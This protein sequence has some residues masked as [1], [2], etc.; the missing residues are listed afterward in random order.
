MI[1]RT[2]EGVK[3]DNYINNMPLFTMKFIHYM[4]SILLF[5]CFWV[6]FRYGTFTLSGYGF[7]YNYYVTV[8]YA[9]ILLLFNRTYNAYLLGFTRV[10]MLVF[11][12]FLS[13]FFSVAIVWGGAT[14]AWRQFHA[15]WMLLILLG[16]QLIIDI[17]WSLSSTSIYFKM[18]EVK[19]TVFVYRKDLDKLR[20]GSIKG[21]SIEKLYKIEKEIQ[22]DGSFAELREQLIGYD[23]IFVAGVNSH[24]RNGILKF[25]KEEGIPG[26]FLPHVGDVIMQDATHI[27]SFDT[28]VLYVNRKS[29][30][31]EYAIIKRAFDIVASLLGIIVLSPIMLITALC[32][33]IY[34]GGPALYKQVRLTKNGREFNVL[35]FRSM[36]VDAE[37]DGVARLS[38][39][40]L[41]SRVTPIGKVIRKCRAD[42]IPQLFNILAGS[43]S[44]VGPRPERPEIAMQYYEIMPDFQ[45]RLQVRAGL[46]GYAQVYGRYNTDPYQKLEFDLL[47]IRNMNVL[48]DIRLMFATI[49]ILFMKEST[50]GIEEGQETAMKLGTREKQTDCM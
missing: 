10:R 4:L 33:K 18:N 35:K 24:C 48:T 13:Q 45:L 34:D 38:T 43:M 42:E 36:S 46:T 3:R 8:I 49:S 6:L 14:I 21:K 30:N 47:Y 16:I 31:V 23:A 20:F 26:Y 44:I 40:T 28:P 19:R 25:C 7:R 2:S 29:L 27:Q 9:V 41:D 22:Y 37:K 12:Q 11:C 17:A 1:K 39:G 5:F 50:E 32:I 15:P